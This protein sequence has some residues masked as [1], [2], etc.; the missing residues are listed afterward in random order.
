MTMVVIIWIVVL[1]PLVVVV[2]VE[3]AFVIDWFISFKSETLST[4]FTFRVTIQPESD[5]SSVDDPGM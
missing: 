4:Y 2:V 5:G 3:V 1:L